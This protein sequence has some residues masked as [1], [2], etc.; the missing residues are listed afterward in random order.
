MSRLKLKQILSNLQYNANT[1]QLIVSGSD[2]DQQPNLIISGSVYVV[3]TNTATGS[4]TIEGIDNF[5]DSGSFYS[6]DLGEY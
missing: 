3:S 6:V 4:V 1:N 2:N 5:G